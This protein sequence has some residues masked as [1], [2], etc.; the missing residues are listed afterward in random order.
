MRAL[1]GLPKFFM[2]IRTLREGAKDMSREKGQTLVEFALILPILLLVIFVIVE[3]GRIF[4]AYI[5]VQH[6]AREGARYAITGRWEEE[7][8]EQ[9]DPRVDSIEKVAKNSLAGLGLD[10]SQP[11][12]DGEGRLIIG[13]YEIKIFG[14][15]PN[16]PPPLLEGYAGLPSEKVA[17]QVAYRLEIITPGLNVIAPSVQVVGYAEMINEDFGQLGGGGFADLREPPSPIPPE[18]P[19][20][21]ASPTPTDTP[22]G[23]TT[24]TP[25]IT[26]TP[27]ETPTPSS[28]PACAVRIEEPVLPGDSSVR[29]FGDPGDLI[30]LRDMDAGGATIG[31]GTVGPGS[32]CGGWVDIIPFNSEDPVYGHIIAAISTKHS[33]SDTACVGVTACWPTA[34]PTA[35]GTTTPTP[36]ATPVEPYIVLDRVCS[37]EREAAD[38]QIRGYNWEPGGTKDIIIQWDGDQKDKFA[39]RATWISVIPIYD[40]EASAGTHAVRARLVGTEDEDTKYIEIPCPPIPTPT[41]T[42]TPLRPDLRITDIDVPAGSPAAYQPVTF[43]V[44]IENSGPGDALSLFWVDLYDLPDGSTAP[45][46]GQTTGDAAWT[47]VGSLG[48]GD[49]KTVVLYY[50]FTQ[51]GNREIYGYVDTRQNIAETEEGNNVWGPLNLNIA[52]GTPPSSTLTTDPVCSAEGISTTITVRGEGWPDTGNIQIWYDGSTPK[53][54]PFPSQVSWSRAITIGGPLETD[55][56]TH[57]IQA[58]ISDIDPPVSMQTEYYIPCSA[59]GTIDGYT[60]IFIK[61]GVVPHG[62]TDV[63]C[64]DGDGNLIAQTTSDDGAYYH[65]KVVPGINYTVIGQ[66]YIDDVLYRD[67]APGISASPLITSRVNL[68]LLPLY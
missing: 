16:S 12:Y 23:T 14:Q 41:I 24:P 51:S 22:T 40:Y 65:M 66:T 20:A 56:R 1:V 31:T 47:A 18:I 39:S 43:T 29:V 57:T 49:T 36:T 33:S 50:A 32:Y 55:G 63:F 27:T 2:P 58:I 25:T 64:E 3:S 62:R 42:A 67:T 26:G 46:A 28:T 9:P 59:I 19:T 10:E 5:T 21:G 15:N 8:A 54:D 17:V 35:T 11:W 6:A 48:T 45:T 61:G 4:Q 34:T 37:P 7:F 44:D 13:H 52:A 53:G 30:D 38:I 68:V 60:W